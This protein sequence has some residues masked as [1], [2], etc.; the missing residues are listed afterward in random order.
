MGCPRHSLSAQLSLAQVQALPGTV[1][2]ALGRTLICSPDPP[3]SKPEP[4]ARSP[5]SIQHDVAAGG[6]G[7]QGLL[8]SF[9]QRASS[10]RSHGRSAT[11][12]SCATLFSPHEAHC[13]QRGVVGRAWHR[14]G[15]LRFFGL[16]AFGSASRGLGYLVCEMEVMILPPMRPCMSTSDQ[17]LV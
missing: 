12:P 15:L 6:L 9:C 8:L 2:T 7:D 1:H 3:R 16:E 13:V 11:P 4:P 10:E 17:S 5:C 14:T